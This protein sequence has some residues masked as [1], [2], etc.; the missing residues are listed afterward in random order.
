MY[1]YCVFFCFFPELALGA[2]L[3]T[4]YGYRPLLGSNW[5][6][7]PT[8]KIFGQTSNCHLV[9]HLLILR[10]LWEMKTW[11]TK[12]GLSFP[13][14]SASLENVPASWGIMFKL[15]GSPKGNT[16]KTNKSNK[17]FYTSKIPQK[18]HNFYRLTLV[19]HMH[20][21]CDR[22]LVANCLA[23][24]PIAYEHLHLDRKVT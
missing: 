9:C 21:M 13:G 23:Q 18:K 19:V 8:N 11:P 16:F 4:T 2:L 7:W 17:L 24:V 14:A 1:Y 10:M 3:D 6:T 12:C 22:I 20:V 15:W 5:T